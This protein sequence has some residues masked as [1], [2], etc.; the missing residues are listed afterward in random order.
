[1]QLWMSI[2]EEGGCGCVWWPENMYQTNNGVARIY[3]R[4]SILE[5]APS[6][7][8]WHF[9]VHI[10][11]SRWF[12]GLQCEQHLHWK[13]VSKRI[14]FETPSIFQS[15]SESAG[16]LYDFVL[17][18]IPLHLVFV[19]MCFICPYIPSEGQTNLQQ[20]IVK[21]TCL[22]RDKEIAFCRSTQDVKAQAANFASRTDAI[23]AHDLWPSSDPTG[24]LAPWL[25]VAKMLQDWPPLA[26][27]SVKSCQIHMFLKQLQKFHFS[28]CQVFEQTS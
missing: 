5:C 24:L 9:L 25:K 11:G 10:H 28:Y 4:I 26:S 21:K 23:S 1:M 27:T 16:L 18:H 3:P 19:H 17:S 12:K 8:I 13:S 7:C 15:E 2:V 20:I 22:V 14:E 6:L